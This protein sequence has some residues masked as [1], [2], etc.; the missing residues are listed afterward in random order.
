MT[1]MRTLGVDLAAADENTAA[2]RIDWTTKPAAVEAF[3]CIG[4]DQLVELI[5]DTDKAV[6]C[7]RAPTAEPIR[8]PRDADGHAHDLLR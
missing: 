7:F 3:T 8:S 4:D 2:C 1:R 6:R 5:L